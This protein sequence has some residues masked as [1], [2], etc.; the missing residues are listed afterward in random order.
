[1]VAKNGYGSV[2]VEYQLIPLGGFWAVAVGIIKD[3]SS[4]SKKL[5]IA[6]GRIKGTIRLKLGK[7]TPEIDNQSDPISQVNRLNVKTRGEWEKIKVLVE[8]YLTKLEKE[9]AI[10]SKG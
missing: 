6:K 9:E 4:G 7:P 1:M 10:T 2:W 3:K 8:E 5:R